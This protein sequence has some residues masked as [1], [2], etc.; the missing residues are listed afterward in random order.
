MVEGTSGAADLSGLRGCGSEAALVGERLSGLEL[1]RTRETP[2]NCKGGLL[3]IQAGSPR[4]ATRSVQDE[5]V[6]VKFIG[7]RA[8]APVKAIRSK[9]RL[10]LTL[11]CLTGSVGRRKAVERGHPRG[12]P[13]EPVKLAELGKSVACARGSSKL[14]KLASD[15]R[16][17][18]LLGEEPRGQTG[19]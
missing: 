11:E 2:F 10:A 17:Q 5:E 16:F 14:Q 13:G 4:G 18:Q 7:S 1:R 15:A 12:K 6:G 3:A 9:E 19:V 8:I